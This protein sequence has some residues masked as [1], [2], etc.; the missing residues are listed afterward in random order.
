MGHRERDLVS[1][2]LEID[3][4]VKRARA[5]AEREDDPATAPPQKVPPADP[6]R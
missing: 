4:R 1:Y 6:T 2:F 3:A 5:E